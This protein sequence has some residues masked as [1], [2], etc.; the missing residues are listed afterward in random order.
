M[1]L[2]NNVDVSKLADELFERMRELDAKA[3]KHSRTDKGTGNTAL[4]SVI[5]TYRG[6]DSLRDV[7]AATGLH[8]GFIGRLERGERGA[9][10]E[11]VARL[12]RYFG[13]AFAIDYLY[14]VLHHIDPDNVGPPILTGEPQIEAGPVAPPRDEG[15]YD[16][17]SV[18]GYRSGFA[19]EG[20]AVRSFNMDAEQAYAVQ[21]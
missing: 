4:G 21:R 18:V 2:K 17:P 12:M 14:A 8:H 5:R 19:A 11:T 20:N 3:S 7:S 13:T 10:V 16:A 9:S 1:G 15:G 6:E